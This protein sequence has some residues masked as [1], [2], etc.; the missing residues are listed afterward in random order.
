MTTEPEAPLLAALRAEWTHLLIAAIDKIEHCQTQLTERQLCMRPGPELNSIANL[1][2][3]VAGNL[4]QWGVAG[5]GVEPDD[6]D[7]P[8]EFADWEPADLPTLNQQFIRTLSA[9]GRL[10][11]TV[12]S[13]EL[14]RVRTVQGF[15]VTGLQALSHTVSHLVGHTHQIIQLTRWQLGGQYRFHWNEAT[16][17]TNGVPL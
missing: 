10:I 4:Q 1:L 16:P 3:H 6:R 12:S 5:F 17:R 11:E 8:A 9:V 14:L 2:A 7:R 15:S 13:E